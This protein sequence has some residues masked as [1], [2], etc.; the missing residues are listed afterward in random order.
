MTRIFTLLIVIFGSCFF[1]AGSASAHPYEGYTPNGVEMSSVYGV[2]LDLAGS[3]DIQFNYDFPQWDGLS[4]AE[5]Y[6]LAGA[7]GATGQN[8]LSPWWQEVMFAAISYEGFTGQWPTA[9]TPE[10]IDTIED[11]HGPSLLREE[12]KSPISGNYPRLD[13]TGFSAGD[14]Y[15]RRLTNGEAATLVS[16]GANIISPAAKQADIE[17]GAMPL[18]NPIYVRIYG[19]SQVIAARYLQFGGMNGGGSN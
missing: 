19:Q 2:P 9:I 5:H 11:G 6:M 1:F 14:M 3:G 8:G 12:L 16:Q 18:G 10:V 13:V 15:M 17:A 4:A 7:H